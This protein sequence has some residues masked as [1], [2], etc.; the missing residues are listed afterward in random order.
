MLAA[1]RV[2]DP[3]DRTHDHL[4]S[5]CLHPRMYREGPLARPSRDLARGD[6]SNHVLVGTHLLAV[7]R[8]QHQ[9]AAC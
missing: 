4:E 5:D 6:L 2:R 8:R 7:E 9:L 1:I 3:E